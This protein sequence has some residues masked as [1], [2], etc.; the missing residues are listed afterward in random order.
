[1]HLTIYEAHHCGL[2]R[3]SLELGRLVGRTFPQLC[4]E[5]IDVT[6]G[7][8]KDQIA[9]AVVPTYVLNG[10]LIFQGNPTAAELRRRLREGA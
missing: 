6:S 9:V 4:V 10:Q 1:M 2:C 7:E 5:V 3:R 8:D